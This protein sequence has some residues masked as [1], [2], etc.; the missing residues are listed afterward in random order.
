VV[1]WGASFIAT[2]VA[3][4]DVSPVTVVWL[5]F[6]IGV[7]ILGA[8]VFLRSEF[9]WPRRKELAYFALLGFVGSLSTSG[10]N[11]L[12]YS[13]LRLRP[14]PGSSR[15]RRSSWLIGMVVS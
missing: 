4:R 3:L 15:P 14:P 12:D 5:R 7:A 10:C 6:A 13:P 2:K 11:R 9:A 1:V 8:A